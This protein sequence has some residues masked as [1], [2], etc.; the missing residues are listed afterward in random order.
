MPLNVPDAILAATSRKA[1]SPVEAARMLWT[2]PAAIS[3]DDSL[4]GWQSVPGMEAL[5]A[6][7]IALQST[8]SDAMPKNVTELRSRVAT[9]A[10]TTWP[11]LRDELKKGDTEVTLNDLVLLFKYS[12]LER[13][14]PLRLVAQLFRLTKAMG[15]PAPWKGSE[16]LAGFLVAP[17][18]VPSLF[19]APAASALGARER[20]SD[21]TSGSRF[22][23][24]LSTPR[25]VAALQKL[26]AQLAELERISQA[27]DIA[28]A[29]DEAGADASLFERLTATLSL[30]RHFTQAS[31][32]AQ[33][34][35]LRRS[36]AR[37]SREV[38]N[39][40]R[41]VS[42]GV[43]GFPVVMDV[44]QAALLAARARED[45]ATRLR[46][47]LP[48]TLLDQLTSLGLEVAD[49][50][51]ID[52]LIEEVART[53]SYLKPAGRSD[54]LVVRQT[55]TGYR[56]AE[57]AYVENVLVGET[58]TREHTS[59]VLSR[60]EFLSGLDVEDEESK[61]LRVTD[62]SELSIEVE[63]VIKEDLNAKG[64]VVV[65]SRGPTIDVTA[66]A[67]LAYDHSTE[68]AAGSAEQYA[69]ETVDRAVERTLTRTKEEARRLF[70]LETVEV[71]THVLSGIGEPDHIRGVYQYL[72]RVSRARIYW[73]G[74]RELYDILVPEPSALIWSL[75]AAR[76]D[77]GISVLPPDAEF[78]AQLTVDNIHLH[79]DRVI[80][81]LRVQDIPPIPPDQSTLTLPIHASTGNAY[82][83]QK[84]LR[85]PE[86]YEVSKAEYRV[87]VEVEDN[88]T[89]ST[90]CGVVVGNQIAIR[91]NDDAW[92]RVIEGEFSFAPRLSGPTVLAGIQVDNY[93]T[94]VG[95][96]HI[97]LEI[98]DEAR[99][100]WALDAYARAVSRFEQQRR[101]YEAAIREAQAFAGEPVQ[102]PIGSRQRLERLARAEMQRGAI[103]IMRNSPVNYDMSTEFPFT[104]PDG[105]LSDEA[106][107]VTDL[108]ALAAS[109]PE[110]Q[111]LQQAFEWE[112]LSWI[113]YPYFWGERSGWRRKATITHP[114]PDFDAFLN[115]GAARVQVPVRPGFEALVRH[116]METLEIYGGDGLPQMGDDGYL[117]FIDE[118]AASLGEPGEEV[119][120]PPDSPREWD[121]VSPTPLVLARPIVDTTL[122]SW[123]P[124]DGAEL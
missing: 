3:L 93:H 13:W 61:D 69:H 90:D 110:I 29:A 89:P 97:T 26:T 17:L 49:L 20:S 24:D 124:T 107:P 83:V 58:R 92:Q 56:R 48:K 30:G 36:I 98:S 103:D 78:F 79:L 60:E 34:Q 68:E 120:W 117:P 105:S 11:E 112:H 10:A 118:Q 9:A 53:P 43:G 19:T 59:R 32:R 45:V 46:R 109:R 71:N 102:L 33:I 86:G 62:S 87:S 116:Y 121:V 12:A 52:D 44:N 108:P 123:D 22:S 119:P 91:S 64:S 70:E 23:F 1:L 16:G 21:T 99:H 14:R 80:G 37:E 95:N 38:P 41:F 4:D 67:E 57:I 50:L 55:T 114:D 94:V 122:P 75:A 5:Q 81:V 77:L 84:E 88:P 113:L 65:T 111:F 72:E 51:C 63:N 74:E 2:T 8:T 73:Y 100:E 66:S 35:T 82:V 6:G 96:I 106:H 76:S 40:N 18:H 39:G 115:A 104:A 27:L 7:W 54:L 28:R 42:V 25:A 101:E 47:Q 85:V 31:L 15:S